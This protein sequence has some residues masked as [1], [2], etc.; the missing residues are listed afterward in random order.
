MYKPVTLRL[1]PS[2]VQGFCAYFSSLNVSDLS[3]KIKRDFFQVIAL[4]ILL[5]GCTI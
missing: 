3:D 2:I 1:I 5:Y 4:S